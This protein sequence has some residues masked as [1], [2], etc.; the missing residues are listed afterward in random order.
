VRDRLDEIEELAQAVL[1]QVRGWAAGR[2]GSP[3]A[4]ERTVLRGLAASSEAVR[5]LAQ[6]LESGRLRGEEAAALGEAIEK[7]DQRLAFFQGCTMR[8][9]TAQ[10]LRRDDD[11]EPVAVE[12][13]RLAAAARGMAG[14]FELVEAYKR[15]EALEAQV[16]ELRSALTSGTGPEPRVLDLPRARVLAA[17]RTIGGL[18]AALDASK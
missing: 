7:A 12:A 8:R 2:Q 9:S 17:R 1:D 13:E 15:A 10:A 4:I 6:Q 14:L 16:A 18:I 11:A 3:E 5:E